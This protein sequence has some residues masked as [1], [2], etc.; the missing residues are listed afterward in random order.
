MRILLLIIL[1]FGAC[2]DK[3]AKE[4]IEV[5]FNKDEVTLDTNSFNFLSPNNFQVDPNLPKPWL[6]IKPYN[7]TV[8]SAE[9]VFTAEEYNSFTNLGDYESI[10]PLWHR[11]HLIN[12]NSIPFQQDISTYTAW[13]GYDEFTKKLQH[14]KSITSKDIPELIKNWDFENIPEDYAKYM[15]PKTIDAY[16]LDYIN[17]QFERNIEYKSLIEYMYTLYFYWIELSDTHDKH[18]YTDYRLSYFQKGEKYLIDQIINRIKWVSQDDR[19]FMIENKEFFLAY[20]NFIVE[21]VG[22]EPFFDHIFRWDNA[23]YYP[24]EWLIYFVSKGLD[25]NRTTYYTKPNQNFLGMVRDPK[26]HYY[27]LRKN[28]YLSHLLIALGYTNEIANFSL[29]NYSEYLEYSFNLDQRDPEIYF[30]NS[31]ICD[32][33]L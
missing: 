14:L 15:P 11:I 4:K 9:E 18:N 22:K 28:P 6:D 20:I 1:L 23:S 10:Q 8:N 13:K 3:K 26:I 25:P 30:E 29:N 27:Y 16:Y 31:E 24:S 21:K 33:P 19:D 5:T 12:T 2:A 7:G 32:A 17:N